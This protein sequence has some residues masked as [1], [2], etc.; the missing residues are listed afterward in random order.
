[1]VSRTPEAESSFVRTPV[2]LFAAPKGQAESSPGQGV[3]AVRKDRLP[4]WVSL[5]SLTFPLPCCTG[6]GQRGVGSIDCRNLDPS[7]P[8]KFPD[9]CLHKISLPFL[10]A[11]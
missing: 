7:R 5:A 9:L 3:V 1:M 8:P 4:P 10:R 6:G 2:G 11:A